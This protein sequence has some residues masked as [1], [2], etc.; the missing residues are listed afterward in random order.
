[1]S[2]YIAYLLI[3]SPHSVVKLTETQTDQ[4]NIY[5]METLSFWVRGKM[6]NVIQ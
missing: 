5:V 3:N 1:M 6:K 2:S 4:S